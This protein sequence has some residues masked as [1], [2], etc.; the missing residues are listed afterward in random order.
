MSFL[1]II[2]N[3]N[4]HKIATSLSIVV[5]MMWKSPTSESVHQTANM[6]VRIHMTIFTTDSAIVM[7][8][9]EN[10]VQI[11]AENAIRTTNLIG[12][13]IAEL[14][15]LLLFASRY[16]LPAILT[17]AANFIRYSFSKMLPP[18]RFVATNWLSAATVTWSCT[19]SSMV[20]F[21]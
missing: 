14:S 10:M 12:V 7:W 15:F 20:S 19:R 1:T 6:T 16:S 8:A 5:F 17:L 4:F 11:S 13:L 2:E 3:V 21:T 18:T 9:I